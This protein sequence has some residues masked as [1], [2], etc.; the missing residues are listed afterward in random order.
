VV[1]SVLAMSR[2]GQRLLQ[3]A[4]TPFAIARETGF[5]SSRHLSTPAE[6]HQRRIVQCRLS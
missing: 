5:D 1:D 4:D 3:F 6:A 2:C